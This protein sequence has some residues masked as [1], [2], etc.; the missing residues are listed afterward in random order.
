MDLY[1]DLSMRMCFRF[2]NMFAM[3]TVQITLRLSA[4]PDLSKIVVHVLYL[5]FIK[6]LSSVFLC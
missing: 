1:S 3:S 5:V 6:C 2:A 4:A